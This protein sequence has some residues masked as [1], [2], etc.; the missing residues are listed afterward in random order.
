MTINIGT[1]NSPA[2]AAQL[3]QL[4]RDLGLP[5]VLSQSAVAV[6]LTG[7]TTATQLLSVTIPGGSLG[8]N[9][10]YRITLQ[11]SETNNANNKTLI[12]R[13]SGT[14]FYQAGDSSKTG[15][16]IQ[17]MGWNRGAVGSQLHG[18]TGIGSPWGGLSGAQVT[19]SFST[20]S[21]Q[22][23]QV[24]ATLANAG[25]TF[26]LEGHRVETWYGA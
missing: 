11:T 26:T 3:A 22:T 4:R 25:D 23:L 14:S 1:I 6:P 8:P 18:M 7:T 17:L 16:I 19:T 24:I 15:R 13:M 21:D 5:T 10:G 2:T 12:V 9:G 20:D